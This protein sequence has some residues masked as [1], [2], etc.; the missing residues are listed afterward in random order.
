MFLK[1][2]N[3]FPF[4]LQNRCLIKKSKNIPK[5]TR[6]QFFKIIPHPHWLQVP[7]LKKPTPEYSCWHAKWSFLEKTTSAIISCFP[8]PAQINSTIGGFVSPTA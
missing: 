5:P 3:K 8:P 7:I 1:V 6:A 2:L 4:Q